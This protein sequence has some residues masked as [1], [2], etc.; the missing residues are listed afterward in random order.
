MNVSPDN[1]DDCFGG[2]VELKLGTV[3]V[4]LLPPEDDEEVE[5]EE[6]ER[7]RDEATVGPALESP[8]PTL[9]LLLPVGLGICT[10]EANDDIA[11]QKHTSSYS[12]IHR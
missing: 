10:Q 4:S 12:N 5:E 6:E 2:T 7:R 9:S 8:P 11:I 3:N 1:M